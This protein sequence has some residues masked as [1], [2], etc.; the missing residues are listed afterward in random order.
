MTPADF[1]AVVL[2]SPGHGYYCAAELSTNKKA[3][4]FE[5]KHDDLIP[6]TDKWHTAKRDAYFALATF[7]EAGKRTADNARFLKALFIDMDGYESKK[8]AALA[9]N[10]FLEKTGL[11]VL[12]TPW[13][14]G[15]GGGLH[16]YWPLDKEV[17]VAS[18]KPV[19]ENF[20]RLCKQES[21]AIDMTVTADAA[22]VLRVPGTTNF[23]KKYE[24]P[25]PVKLLSTGDVFSLEKMGT[26]I[27]SLLAPEQR[28]PIFE[29]IAGA[30][31]KQSP[32]KAQIKLFE[33][34]VTLFENIYD[35]TNAGHGCAQ[36][37]NY[38][39]NPKEDGLEP[40]WRG[41]LSWTKVCEDGEDWATWLSDLHPY[42]DA[43]M[44]EKLAAIKGPYPCVKMDS[45]NPGLC[46]GC[47]HFGKIT[48]P[49][50]LG[51]EIKTDNT[52]KVIPLTPVHEPVQDEEEM[53]GFE[54]GAEQDE[55]EAIA[56]DGASIIRP[57]PPRG[58]SYGTNGGIY[59]DRV[60]EDAD[61]TKS[62][63]QVQ[64]LA[65]DL[66][67][68]DMLKQE[69]DYAVH[70]VATRPEGVKNVTMPSK[71]VV[72]KDET[73]KFLA[74]QN[75][76]ASFGKGNDANLFDYVRACV[77]EASLSR[78]AIDVPLQYGWQKDGS[79]V[80][81]GRVFT[82][83]GR[84]VTLPMPGLENLTNN[85]NSKGTL[86]GWRQFWDMMSRKKMFTM[87]AMCLDSFG[88]TLMRFSEYEGFVWYIGSTESGTGKSLTLSAKAGVWGHPIRYRTGKG[89]SP[90]AMQQRAGLLNSMP[91]L[92]DE[93][94]AKARNDQEWVPSFIFDMSEG[95]GKERMES[96]ANKERVNNS[97][98]N[99]T[100]TM[101]GNL[102]LTDYMA[103]ARK[104]SS[105]GELLRML[106]WT[107]NVALQWTDDERKVLKLI[108]E[109]Y[110][111]AGEAWVRWLVRNQD[112]AQEMYRR[113]YAKLK[114][115][116]EFS[117]D[118][119]Y[120]HAACTEIATAGVLLGPKFANLLQVPL[121][122][123]I[124]ALD[125]LVKKARGVLRRSVRT[126]E[127]VLNAYTR[128]NYGGFI[129]V[130]KMEG[131]S[132]LATWGDGSDT[133]DT[134]ITRSKVLGRIEHNTLQPGFV[135]YFIEEQL[136]KQH[137]V[138]MSF[139]Y[140]DFRKQLEATFK[141]T[142]TKKDMLAKT[143]GPSMRVNVM[144]ISRPADTLDEDQLSLGQAEKG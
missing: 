13:I 120:W 65:Y 14:V 17:D 25:R 52:E 89:T 12:G 83:D 77:E 70:L 142:Y 112:L 141:V 119:R 94:T 130:R 9:L 51:R 16:V 31:P 32:G 109:N 23:K 110:G 90:V 99:T 10:A 133:K 131:K 116:M 92:I 39:D 61:G 97:T 118:E 107:P 68:V 123:V 100:C 124:D 128:D 11:D 60:T 137:C 59:C 34:S 101:S 135:E 28:A 3:H 139:G 114:V 40:I 55:S 54:E 15:S 44:R 80:Y 111:V 81:N 96:G 103:G 91:L 87:L 57:K 78:K 75:I 85:T 46:A 136:L 62:K 56:V 30:R 6:H 21:L 5:E 36:L 7:E 132:I 84:E 47:P 18:W 140:A 50:R 138:S 82:K 79:F 93:I 98:W 1:L 37:K 106:E 42:T 66:F 35:A 71:C 27:N 24:T 20:K 127:D 73:V 117:D 38:I 105:N 74:S 26:V 129:V 49:L 69:G 86:D 45:E 29:A 115:K 88:C 58:F 8:A 63:K 122:G 33:N 104:H 22:R 2:P 102:H 125:V 95:Q 53:F 64:I 144:H 126:A 113:I 19:A 43:R 41:L 134:S 72:S 76:I 4:A 121:D 48:N 67:V 143:N 108:K